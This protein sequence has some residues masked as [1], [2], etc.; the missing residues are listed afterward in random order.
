MKRR[1]I[2]RWLP[3]ETEQLEDRR[4]LTGQV[5]SGGQHDIVPMPATVEVAPQYDVHQ[6]PRLQLGDAPLVGSPAY[7]GLDQVE[8]IWQT[9]QSGAGLQDEF[10]ASFRQRGSAPWNSIAL[11]TAV[12]TNVETRIM[13]SAV[14]T[15]LEWDTEYEYQ[16]VHLRA[17]AEVG[18]YGSEFRT[19]VAPGNSKP[20]SFAAYGDSATPQFIESFRGVQNQINA[21]GVDFAVLLGDNI[22]PDGTH[23]DAD[24]RFTPTLNPEAIEWNQSHIDYLA[25]GNH[26]VETPLASQQLYSVPIPVAGVSSHLDVPLNEAPEFNYS[27][28]YGDVHFTVIDSTMANFVETEDIQ[29]RIRNVIDY[30]V[31]DMAATNA[32]WKIVVAHNPFVGTDKSREPDEFYFQTLMAGLNSVGVDLV[33]TGDSHTYSWTYPMSGFA[34]NNQDGTVSFD[35]VKFVQDDDRVYERGAGLIQVVSG[36]GGRDHRLAEYTEPVFAAGYSLRDFT[37]PI[38]FGFAK[39]EVSQRAIVISYISAETGNIVGDKNGDGQQDTNEPYFGQFQIQDSSVPNG[40]LDLNQII[41]VSDI[42]LLCRQVSI[43]DAGPI[44]F[45]IA[46]DGNLDL[47]DVSALLSNYFGT[48]AGDVNLDGR[49]NSSD[50][51]EVFTIGVY[52]T[53]R[54]ATWQ[55]GDWNC[56]G[57]F[58]TQDVVWAFQ[59]N[60]YLQFATRAS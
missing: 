57:R 47:N 29:A 15:G 6:P 33:L 41:S 60:A 54:L 43:N 19:R 2:R 48:Q 39:L 56:D 14:V 35:E 53:D 8:I 20:F 52:E 55:Q 49:F 21:H 27:F 4:L 30:A 24:G 18:T 10:R 58:D 34:D 44:R 17:G 50:L 16:V 5:D 26:D 22:Y 36:V 40:D 45:D 9:K 12:S 23:Q 51:V 7:K 25:V 32:K 11:S 1:K 59:V 3:R 42:D 13:H 28:D 46:K 37:G 38:E 31:A